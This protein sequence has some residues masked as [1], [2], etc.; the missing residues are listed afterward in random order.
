MSTIRKYRDMLRGC[1]EKSSKAFPRIVRDE[2]PEVVT[3]CKRLANSTK[4]GSPLTVF[5][6]LMGVLHQKRCVICGKKLRGKIL[7]I[8][9]RGLF[10]SPECKKRGLGQ[11]QREGMMR[12]YG[13]PNCSMLQEVKEKKRHS[14]IEKYGVEN[15]AQALEVK[16]KMKKT[17]ME[18]YE[19]EYASQSTVVK[20]KISDSWKSRSEEEYKQ[21][22]QRISEKLLDKE[23]FLN[24]LSRYN[25]T[26]ADG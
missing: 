9:N 26:L 7:Y 22:G 12:K 10:C 11:C 17:N 1:V 18:R 20:E 16:E 19:T 6:I 15:V 5:K 2:Y 3:Y 4:V 24:I 14:S 23:G 25:L 8:E 21:I 13:V